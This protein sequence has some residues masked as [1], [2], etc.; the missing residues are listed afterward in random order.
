M[1]TLDHR[2]ASP[3]IPRRMAFAPRPNSTLELPRA[4]KASVT[5]CSLSSS[6]TARH[7]L[8]RVQIAGVRPP[9]IMTLRAM[10]LPVDWGAEDVGGG[11]GGRLGG[12][13]QR[14]I[15]SLFVAC[16]QRCREE[17]GGFAVKQGN[18]RSNPLLTSGEGQ[19]DRMST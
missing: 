3:P 15:S 4:E 17:R 8:G 16:N 7:G 11:R 18:S 19:E 13:M 2:L 12:E 5:F 9:A 1:P 14:V 10:R 6:A